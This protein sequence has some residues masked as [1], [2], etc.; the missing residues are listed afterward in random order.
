MARGMTCADTVGSAPMRIGVALD[1]RRPGERNRRR[2][3]SAVIA[4]AGMAQ[5]D[6]ARARD[7]DAAP[8]ALDDGDAERLFQ[9]A[10]G[11]GHRRRADMQEVGGP[12]PRFSGARPPEMSGGGGTGCGFRS[13]ICITPELMKWPQNIILPNQMPC[14]MWRWR[15]EIVPFVTIGGVTLHHRQVKAA[16]NARAIVFINSLGTDFRIWDDVVVRACRRNSHA[17]LRQARPR[18]LRCR[19]GIQLD[20]RSCRRSRRRCSIIS[21]SEK[22]VLCGLSVGGLIAQGLYARRPEL[23]EALILCDTAHKIGTAESWNAR[24]A[25]VEAQG[26]RGRSPMACSK[27]GSRPP[28][29]PSA[30][31]SLPAI[32][33]C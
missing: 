21:V 3:L 2:C 7:P 29:T 30:R 24:I 25:T 12:E 19:R 23:V 6:L 15:I 28:S 20:R 18:P 14:A 10:H 11:L 16:G 17:G 22:V 1:R 33:T 31:P 32:A 9:L 27:C 5:E 4:D 26:H 13:W 8:V